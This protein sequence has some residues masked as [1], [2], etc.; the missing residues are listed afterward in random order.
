MI[1]IAFL[2]L[3]L[4]TTFIFGGC[5]LNNFVNNPQQIQ[6]V[7]NFS[8]SSSDETIDLEKLSQDYEKS[9]KDAMAEFWTTNQAAETKEIVLNLKTPSQ[10]LDLHLKLVIALDEVEQGQLVADQSQI[11]SGMEK[12]NELSNQYSFIK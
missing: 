7:E 3:I 5:K 9:L 10:Y 2:I 1:R 11:D 12:I 6:V 4:S 8:D